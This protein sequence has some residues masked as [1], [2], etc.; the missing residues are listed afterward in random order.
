[1]SE[2]GVGGLV[3]GSVAGKTKTTEDVSSSEGEGT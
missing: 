2:L 3:G 1:M